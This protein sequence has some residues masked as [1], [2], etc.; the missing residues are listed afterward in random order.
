MLQ[1]EKVLGRRDYDPSIAYRQLH[2]QMQSQYNQ[3]QQSPQQASP[4]PVHA[5]PTLPRPDM[6][7]AV[8]STQDVFPSAAHATVSSPH[9]ASMHH[10]MPLGNITNTHPS[11]DVLSPRHGL[12]H[13]TPMPSLGD[14]SRIMDY[15]SKMVSRL[16][17]TPLSVDPANFALGN[18]LTPETNHPNVGLLQ[19]HRSNCEAC[20]TPHHLYGAHPHYYSPGSPPPGM[21]PSLWGMDRDILPHPGIENVPLE[22]PVHDIRY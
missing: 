9:H 5:T 4:Y 22:F 3:Q 13:D 15:G 7:Y 8:V 11:L 18:P 6:R 10:K 14:T 21:Y 20:I 19:I 1:Y 16:L 2:Q 17:E 12:M